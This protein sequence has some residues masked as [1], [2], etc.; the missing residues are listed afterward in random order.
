MSDH[1]KTVRHR[2]ATLAEHHA[3]EGL[4]SIHHYLDKWWMAEAYRQIAAGKAPGIDGVTKAEYGEGLSHR[5]EDLV[6]RVRS[7]SYKAPPVKRAQIPKGNGEYRNLGLPTLED[8]VLQK[9]F[10]M[11]VEP[12]FE[13]EFYDCSYGF[14]AGRNPHQAVKALHKKVGDRRMHWVIDLDLRKYFDT[15]PHLK[16]REMFSRRIR[17]GV[18]NKLVLG[19]LKAGV[20]HEEQVTTSKEGTPQGGIVS[21]LLSNLYLHEVLDD[22]FVREVQPRMKG[23]AQMVRYADD[24]VLCFEQEEDA[25]RVLA[26]LGK[27]MAK[28][29]LKLHPEKTKLV[30]FRPP[31]WGQ[32]K[33]RG[34]FSFLG[35]CFYW[36]R[37]RKGRAIVKLK[38]AK[39]RWTRT[40]KTQGEWLRRNR[41]QPVATQH[42]QLSVKLR[43]HFQYFGVTFNSRAPRNLV[44]EV[45]KRWRVC[46]NRRGGRKGW[47]W[48]RFASLLVTYPYPLPRPRIIHHLFD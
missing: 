44:E 1:V 8:K 23:A 29:G 20:L 10:V 37:S 26:V 4:T 9:S 43:G 18:L 19:W 12:I 32:R 17:D 15:I 6:N 48:E 34:S 16:L 38:T 22:W 42:A 30:D 2:I 47:S 7:R 21:P 25:K 33:G 14:R 27:R 3:S 31:Q 41:H 24:A 36:G 35:F 13:R 40:A 46:L 11:L 45:K 28:Y 39:E 5:L